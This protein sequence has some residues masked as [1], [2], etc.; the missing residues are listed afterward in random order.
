MV[1]KNFG[2]IKLPPDAIVEGS[3]REMGIVSEAIKIY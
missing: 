1:L 2:I 3:I